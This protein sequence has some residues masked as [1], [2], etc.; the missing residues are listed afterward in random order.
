MAFE[1][2][3]RLRTA[4]LDDG[5]AIRQLQERNGL[6]SLDPLAW[7]RQWEEYPYAAE[8]RD[9]PMG[10]VLVAGSGRVV[11]SL[12]NIHMLY[13]LG[14]NRIRGAIATAWAVDAPHRGHSL[15]LMMAFLKQKGVGLC[16]NGSASPTA[17]RVLRGMKMSRIPIPGYEVPCFWAARPS[18]FARAALA[19]RSVPAA[20]ILSWPAGMLLS[21]RDVLLRS[22]RGRI[23]SAMHRTGE[24]DHRFDTFW[25]NLSGGPRRLRA[26]RTSAVLDWRF[27][28]ALRDG[29]AAVVT[30]TRDGALNGYAVLVRRQSPELG[31]QLYD[32]ADLQA[33]RDEASTIRDLLLGA[34]GAAREDGMD[35]V[36]FLTGT[37]V[38]RAPATELRPYCYRLKFWQL[39][40]R[41]GTPELGSA[42]SN[43]D[44]WDFSPFDTY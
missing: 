30:A 28:A 21:A 14:G 25:Q 8:F 12:G 10:W 2:A 11:G 5:D 31:M 32:V 23:L 15:Q 13:D 1:G 34:I 44:A 18:G 19:R 24:F 29:Q 26:V 17:S 22:G 20:A 43:A 40:Y 27:G 36:K 42:L 37:P 16:L 3:V 38:K 33:L 39:Y 7:R 9:I 41:A 6:G 35:A 4:A